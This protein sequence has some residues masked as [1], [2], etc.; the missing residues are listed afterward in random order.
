[1]DLPLRRRLYPRKMPVC[2]GVYMV[3]RTTILLDDDVYR[4]LVDESIR[5]YGSTKAL[6]KVLN[7]ELRK[8]LR[9]REKLLKLI[10]SEKLA[11]VS[12]EEFEK[13]RRELSGRLEKR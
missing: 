5:R 8:S 10:Y 9:A 4:A 11:D 13:F 1:M 2:I 12:E 7:E 6:S 3:K